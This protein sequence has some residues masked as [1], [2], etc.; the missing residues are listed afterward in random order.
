MDTAFKGAEALPT[1]SMTNRNIGILAA[2]IYFPSSFVA[3]KDLGSSSRETRR[4]LCIEEYD[5]VSSGK[6][7]SGLG[8][9]RMSFVYDNEDINSICMTGTLVSGFLWSQSCIPAH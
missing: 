4:E 6:Y 2:E 3:Q 7:T 9:D 1:K 8:Q 5:K